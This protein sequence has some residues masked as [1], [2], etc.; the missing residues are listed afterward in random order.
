MPET[1]KLDCLGSCVYSLFLISVEQQHSSTVRRSTFWTLLSV[2]LVNCISHKLLSVNTHT[3]MYSKYQVFIT[4]VC[5]LEHYL[6]VDT[7]QGNDMTRK[8]IFH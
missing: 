6:Y 8:S 3:H 7:C 4:E 5:N 1:P 2:R